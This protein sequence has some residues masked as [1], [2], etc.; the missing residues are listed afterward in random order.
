MHNPDQAWE[1]EHLLVVLL[2]RRVFA[3]ELADDNSG[4]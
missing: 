2:A 4:V 3:L 1:F